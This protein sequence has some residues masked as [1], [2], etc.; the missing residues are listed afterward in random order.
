M[1][2]FHIHDE[3]VIEECLNR[4]RNDDWDDQESWD[5]KEFLKL[6]E[7]LWSTMYPWL[8]S[9]LAAQDEVDDEVTSDS[10]K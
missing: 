3:V 10:A 2:R 8:A 1:H 9:A 5:D 7:K 6:K 4:N